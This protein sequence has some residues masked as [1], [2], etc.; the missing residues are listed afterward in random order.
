MRDQDRDRVEA[1]PGVGGSPKGGADRSWRTPLDP[2][3]EERPAKDRGP[4][5]WF[6]HLL[7]LVGPD[8][9]GG[10]GG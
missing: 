4:R 5:D 7:G 2:E 1:A 10:P 9:R 6:L 8:K 3:R